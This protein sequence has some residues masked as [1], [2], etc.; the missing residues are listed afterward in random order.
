M[1]RPGIRAF[2]ATG[3]VLLT[4]SAVVPA[5]A[6]TNTPGEIP[7]PDTFMVLVVRPSNR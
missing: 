5:S 7:K 4:L 1:S 2:A 3:G 6:Q